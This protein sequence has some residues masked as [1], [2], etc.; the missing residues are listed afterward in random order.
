MK[1]NIRY[2]Y[3]AYTPPRPRRRVSTHNTASRIASSGPR[4][5]LEW[6][7][8]SEIPA[9][10]GKTG[11]GEPCSEGSELRGRRPRRSCLVVLDGHSD[12]DQLVNDLECRKNDL[13]HRQINLEQHQDHRE[14]GRDQRNH[15][16]FFLHIY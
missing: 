6:L 8:T 10:P 7:D 2:I 14:D 5:C 13:E 16:D 12:L 3:P 11:R 15:E 1:S 4:V 9:K